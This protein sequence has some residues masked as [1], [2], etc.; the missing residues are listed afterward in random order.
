MMLLGPV[1]TPG[2][3]SI[4][5]LGNS[6]LEWDAGRNIIGMKTPWFLGVPCAEYVRDVQRAGINGLPEQYRSSQDAGQFFLTLEVASTCQLPIRTNLEQQIP[7][8][9]PGTLR[10]DVQADFRQ[11]PSRVK[12]SISQ[13]H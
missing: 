10:Q 7:M 4:N 1:A 8:R 12:F 3:G 9:L 11:W 13:A 5:T 6:W 2:G